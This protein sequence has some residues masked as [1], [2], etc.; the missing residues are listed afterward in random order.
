MCLHAFVCLGEW[1]RYLSKATNTIETQVEV[2]PL[3]AA[4]M[5]R[6]RQRS[7][8]PSI[9]NTLSSASLSS[10]P[11]AAASSA[12]NLVCKNTR[13]LLRTEKHWFSGCIMSALELHR[14]VSTSL[15][16]SAEMEDQ[17]NR[18]VTSWTLTENLHLSES[19]C[20]LRSHSLSHLLPNLNALQAPQC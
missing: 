9:F 2:A 6:R 3:Q 12:L 15:K 5:R 16:M 18:N 10:L 13:H 17:Q 4:A 1:L 11:V 20:P 14:F 8:S 19:K 7:S